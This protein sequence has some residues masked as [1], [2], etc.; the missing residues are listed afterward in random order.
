[1]LHLVDHIS[2]VPGAWYTFTDCT[3]VNLSSVPGAQPSR[4]EPQDSKCTVLVPQDS[5]ST[6]PQFV[7]ALYQQASMY[8]LCVPGVLSV[9]CP[10]PGAAPPPTQPKD[11]RLDRAHFVIVIFYRNYALSPSTVSGCE[12]PR[13]GLASINLLLTCKDSNICFGFY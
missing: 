9:Y 3:T 7:G 6:V 1:M 10:G 4:G 12:G 13:L 11:A 8:L 5:N 2:T